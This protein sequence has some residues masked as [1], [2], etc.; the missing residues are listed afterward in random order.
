MRD[1]CLL[2][3][4]SF[5]SESWHDA[6][7]QKEKTRLRIMKVMFEQYNISKL[8]SITIMNVGF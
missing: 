1:I 7:Q 3:K 2:L 6:E 5:Y 4:I 8:E